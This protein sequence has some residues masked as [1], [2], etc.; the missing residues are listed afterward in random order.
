MTKCLKLELTYIAMDAIYI[1]YLVN[2]G[3]SHKYSVLHVGYNRSLHFFLMLRKLL[4]C[5]K[6]QYK[7]NSGRH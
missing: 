2:C 5:D 4:L 3:R 1:A 7:T 6:A